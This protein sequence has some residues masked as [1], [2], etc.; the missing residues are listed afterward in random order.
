MSNIAISIKN[1]SK[2]YYLGSKIDEARYSSL[3]ESLA[4]SF[5]TI[6]LNLNDFFSKTTK[7]EKKTSL[8]FW[9]LDDISIDINHGDRLGIVGRNGAGKSTLLKILGRITD[10]TKGRIEINGRIASLLEVGTGFHPELTGRENI[11]LNGTILGMTIAQI[12]NKFEQIVDFAEIEEF[13]D[14]PIKRYSSGM[15]VRLAFSVAAHLDSDILLI[16]EVLAVGDSNF[17]KKCMNKMNEISNESRT[18][19]FVSH[20]SEKIRQFCNKVLWLEKGNIVEYGSA[21]EIVDLYEKKNLANTFESDG[22]FLRKKLTKS[23]HISK[24]SL[25]LLREDTPTVL[26]KYGDT[27]RVDVNISSH[28]KSLSSMYL[29]WSI[30]NEFGQQVGSGN[31]Y[32]AGFETAK[33]PNSISLQFPHLPFYNGKYYIELGLGVN[34]IMRVDT[35]SNEIFFEIY[36]CDPYENGSSFNA[37]SGAV[38]IPHEW[39]RLKN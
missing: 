16:D 27:M 25:N 5:S 24:C 15:Y 29:T 11:F 7:N 22:V 28:G 9:A 39:K 18:I 31:T 19:V 14:T 33:L 6:K 21:K 32:S 20:Q 37:S 3:R 8:E 2:R 4:N 1:I 13:L 36:S 12:R 17:Q 30:Y 26:F 35:W 34:E 23:V 38:F 10:P